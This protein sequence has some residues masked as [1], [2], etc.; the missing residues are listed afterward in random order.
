MQQKQR[1]QTYSGEFSAKTRVYSYA[2]P[3]CAPQ[4]M[5]RMRSSS[6]APYTQEGRETGLRLELHAAY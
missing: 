1:H 2:I 3:P 6:L 5:A 4:P